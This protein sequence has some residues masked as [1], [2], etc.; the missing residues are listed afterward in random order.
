MAKRQSR[1]KNDIII[2][3]RSIP[4]WYTI[5]SNKGTVVYVKVWSIFGGRW[6]IAPFLKATPTI[7]R[8][9]F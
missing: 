9:G 6:E 3:E 8:R 4:A 7:K 5:L 1:H 2:A